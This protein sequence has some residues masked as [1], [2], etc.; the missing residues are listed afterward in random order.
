MIATGHNVSTGNNMTTNTALNGA[1]LRCPTGTLA[2]G[3]LTRH[4]STFHRTYDHYTNGPLLVT[5][6]DAVPFMPLGAERPGE[7]KT[8]TTMLIQMTPL[9]TGTGGKRNMI[10]LVDDDGNEVLDED[11][12]PTMVPKPNANQ[13]MLLENLAFGKLGKKVKMPKNTVFITYFAGGAK[14][15]IPEHFENTSKSVKEII[16]LEGLEDKVNEYLYSSPDERPM[17]LA[18]LKR[19]KDDRPDV[20]NTMRFVSWYF[21]MHV[22]KIVITFNK[23]Q[24][25]V[26]MCDEH[27]T[28]THMIMMVS[29]NRGTDSNK[30]QAGRCKV[31]VGKLLQC[32]LPADF[33]PTIATNANLEA[34]AALENLP[35]HTTITNGKRNVP[36]ELKEHLRTNNVLDKAC[37]RYEPKQSMLRAI[38]E[39]DE[40]EAVTIHP[41]STKLYSIKTKTTIGQMRNH[42]LLHAVDMIYTHRQIIDMLMGFMNEPDDDVCRRWVGKLVEQDFL[43]K[44]NANYT[45]NKQ[46]AHKPF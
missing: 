22:P 2:R 28:I 24:R 30:Q 27:N 15:R 34:A 45:I 4:V 10:P 35:Y 42:V 33:K 12:K 26:D 9:V 18:I 3:I 32:N 25:A 7:F 31:P 17:A 13:T 36:P 39:V 19:F 23:G 1:I 41:D 44:D 5:T 6:R 43:R 46:R 38:G 8:N 40:P 16:K 14:I 11:N 21:G 37:K 20:A 29:E